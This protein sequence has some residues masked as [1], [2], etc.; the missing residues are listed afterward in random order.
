MFFQKLKQLR[1]DAGKNQIDIANHLGISVQSYSAYEAGREPKYEYLVKL[2]N[3][4]N[5]TTDYLLGLSEYKNIGQQRETERQASDL[6]AL[7]DDIPHEDKVSIMFTLKALFDAYGHFKDNKAY[8]TSLLYAFSTLAIS[9]RE[10]VI[11]IS[12]IHCDGDKN[13]S[14]DSMFKKWKEIDRAV[15]DMYS[16]FEELIKSKPTQKGR[17]D[18]EET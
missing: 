1:T 5:C 16:Y 14:L 13:G 2:A 7:F 8:R 15:G 18:N 12:Q 9:T 17:A 11:D 4:F 10:T 6:L 3:Y